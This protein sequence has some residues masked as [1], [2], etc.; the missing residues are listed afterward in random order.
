VSSSSGRR[1]R[2]RLAQSGVPDQQ[3]AKRGARASEHDH[4]YR[5]RQGSAAYDTREPVDE[6]GTAEGSPFALLPRRVARPDGSGLDGRSQPAP[7][8]I[9]SGVHSSHPGKLLRSSAF[10]CDRRVQW[11]ECVGARDSFWVKN[12]RPNEEPGT[13]TR[14]SKDPRPLRLGVAVS[15]GTDAERYIGQVAYILPLMPPEVGLSTGTR[16]LRISCR[17]ILEIPLTNI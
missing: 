15:M 6:V 8:L 14:R 2:L 12:S 1:T 11:A 17:L 10:L 9:D 7:L 4:S 16:F 5:T 3:P 13:L